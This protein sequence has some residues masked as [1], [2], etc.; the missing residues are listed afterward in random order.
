MKD[1]YYQVEL[2]EESRDLTTFSDGVSLERGVKLNLKKCQIGQK[3]IKF[4]GHIISKDGCIPSPDN[5][6][7]IQEMK[8]PNNVKETRRF[9]G[10]CGFYR[11]HIK[12]YAK[13]AVPLTNLLKEKEPF[14]WTQKIVNPALNR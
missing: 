14:L 8:P 10:M 1:A 6:S 7:A 13:I 12:D 3:E 2:D 9:L 4:L 11:K 5:I